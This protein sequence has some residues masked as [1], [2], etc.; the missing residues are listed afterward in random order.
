MKEIEEIK[1]T[2][3]IKWFSNEKGYGYITDRNNIDLY[4]GV[5]DIIGA[6]LPEYGDQV[7]YNEY[8]GRE[9]VP[10]GKDIII[11]ER[12]NP[13]FKKIRCE[14]CQADVKPKPWHFG[15]TDYTNLKTVYLCPNCGDKLYESGGGFNK[16]AKIL[17]SIIG[18]GIFIITFIIV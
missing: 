10:A 8:L 14:S 7:E 11:I 15:G 16:L 3:Y 4:F 18:I 12:K 6:E 1:K 13:T 5:K 9:D 17:L 2:G